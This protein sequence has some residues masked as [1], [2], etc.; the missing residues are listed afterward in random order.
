L[1][2]SH[3][4]LLY[5]LYFP[6]RLFR[7]TSLPIFLD[8]ALHIRWA[9]LIAEGKK[10]WWRPWDWG[11]ALGV[12]LEALV[13]PL[14]GDPLLRDRA[15]SVVM[16]AVTLWACFEIGR[17]LYGPRVG[18]VSALFYVFCPFPLLY[19]RLVLADP[20]LSALGATTLLLSLRLV[21]VPTV[22]WGL[23]LGLAMALVAYTKITGLPLLGIPLLS[24]L[25]LRPARVMVRPLLAA[26]ALAL[27][28]MAY[29][30]LL[31][32]RGSQVSLMVQMATQTDIGF[33][34][35][36]AVNLRLIADWLFVYWT[37]PL[38]IL[39]ATGLLM[40]AARRSRP[41]LLLALL[42]L[43]P[44]LAFSACL[45]RGLPRYL[46]FTS[47]PFLVLA[48]A[49]FS[50]LL[51]GLADRLRLQS[52]GRG[53]LLGVLILLA[54]APALRLDYDVWNDPSRAALPP[55][56]RDQFISGW[57]S[58][59][60]VRDTVA[61]VRGELARYP[62]GITVVTHVTHSRT[63]RLTPL[64]LDL[65]FRNE[66]RVQ[67]EDWDLADPSALPAITAWAAARPTLLVVPRADP[68]SPPPPAD[69]WA[70]LGSLVAQT[71]KPGGELCDEIYRL[72]RGRP[73][74]T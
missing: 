65:E 71:F 12:W 63:L 6:S 74:G 18:L 49:A 50:S 33:L 24:V 10:P 51:D 13:A 57:T 21:E 35:R 70:H 56:D 67:L 64:L 39:G 62:A 17:R 41:G 58:G 30:L 36:L 44:L 37:A 60:G 53:A 8:E 61:F 1:G 7:L 2:R 66:P 34:E 54:I 32:A 15:L 42:T 23:L 29:P 20:L 45:T 40:A 26:H 72:C 5:S 11:R 38:I 68:T 25:L 47:V 59:Y 55:P 28:L 48:A 9:M 22:R 19:D 27:A 43:L 69:T 31:W 3:A 52:A 14:G 16:G 4:L 73:C 46:L